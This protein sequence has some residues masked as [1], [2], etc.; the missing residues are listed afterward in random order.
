MLQWRWLVWVGQVSY[1]VYI[2]HALFGRWLHAHFTLDQ[3]PLIFVSQLGLTL[4]LA[5]LSWYFFESPLLK[6]KRHWPMPSAR[7]GA[8][9]PAATQ[10]RE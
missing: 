1:G 4:P 7:T 5:A 3:A 2:I 9:H 10:T 8:H 6:L